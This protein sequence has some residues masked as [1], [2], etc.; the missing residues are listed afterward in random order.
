[1]VI[2]V[3][4]IIITIIIIAV[5]VVIVIAILRIL[6]LLADCKASHCVASAAFFYHAHIVNFLQLADYRVIK[7]IL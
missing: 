4:I 1:M 5:V 7:L 3:I 6:L 2:I